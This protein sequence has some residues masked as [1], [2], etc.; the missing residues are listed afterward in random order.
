MES[1]GDKQNKKTQRKREEVNFLQRYLSN[2]GNVFSP[3]WIRRP[4]QINNGRKW[5]VLDSRYNFLFYF[6]LFLCLLYISY[7]IIK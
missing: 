2:V 4:I 6:R 3:F 7:E 5:F 1:D